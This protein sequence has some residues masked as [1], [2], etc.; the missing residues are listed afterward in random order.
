M[1]RGELVVS[2]AFRKQD[3]APYGSDPRSDGLTR[4]AGGSYLAAIAWRPIVMFQVLG[5]VTQVTTGSDS[6]EAWLTRYDLSVEAAVGVRL[7]AELREVSG[8]AVDRRGRLFM[9]QDE[10]SAIYEVDPGAGSVMR[11]FHVGRIGLRGDFEGI[12]IAGERFFLST[13]DGEIVEFREASGG[14]VAFQRTFTTGLGKLC[15][16][17]G[18]AFDER[19]GSLL[20]PC[21][22]SR[23]RALRRR[24]TVFALPLATFEVDPDP[25]VSLPW[26]ALERVGLGDGFHPSAVEIHP[27][28][29]S[30]FLLSAQ[31]EAIVEI[32]RDG[33]VLAA[34]SLRR[35][36][37]PQPEGIAFAPDMSL[38]ISDEGSRRGSLRRYPVADSEP[39]VHGAALPAEGWPWAR[40]EWMALRI[41][42]P[43]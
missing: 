21:K 31:E 19:T 15:E 41:G 24:L 34:Q 12:A 7:P 30:L 17:E 5:A 14:E 23:A 9:H 25:R 43:L 27:V 26:E 8:L 29:G 13:S 18:L 37:H 36:S 38:L 11:R 42:P 35:S 10:T 40:I 33:D 28:S 6:G 32:G 3:S 2:N 22:A 20:L 39:T 4:L 1:Q 16:L